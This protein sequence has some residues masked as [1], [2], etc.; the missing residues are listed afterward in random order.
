MD[1]IRILHKHWAGYGW[2]YTSPD[3]PSMTGAESSYAENVK[4][5]EIVAR[6][7]LESEAEERGEPE[8]NLEGLTFE[9]YRTEEPEPEPPVV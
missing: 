9:H 2:S 8:P 4:Q 7:A 3:V 5:S 6:F 1:P